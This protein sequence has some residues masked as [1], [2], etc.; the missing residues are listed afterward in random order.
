MPGKVC[1]L[2]SRRWPIRSALDARRW[3]RCSSASRR[4]VFAAERLHGDDTTVPVLAK[5]KT[6]TGRCWV[7]VRDDR[8]FE[9]RAPPA[10]MFYYSRDRGGAHAEEHLARWRGLLQADAYSGYNKLYAADRN[11]GPDPG[12]GL[13]GACA[14]AVLRARRY[15]GQ[16]AAQG[17]G[18]STSTDLAAGAG[19][20]AAHRS[21]V[22][23]R[24]RHQRQRAPR[25]A[26]PSARS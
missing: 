8:P 18:Q 15:R 9:G 12:G 24:A 1:R 6:H 3:S 14:P 19:D 13:L 11:A 22:R 25:S 10:A 26:V 16:R 4:H 2:R 17:R 7:Y 21:P 20:R 5:G 23:D